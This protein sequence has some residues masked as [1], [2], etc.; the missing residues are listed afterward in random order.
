MHRSL[1]TSSAP[2]YITHEERDYPGH[3]RVDAPN[4]MLNAAGE[5]KSVQLNYGYV[6]AVGVEHLILIQDNVSITDSDPDGDRVNDLFTFQV[7]VPDGTLTQE[8]AV[9][10]TETDRNGLPRAKWEIKPLRIS[11]NTALMPAQATIIGD[12]YQ[13]VKPDL[14]LGFDIKPLVADKADTYVGTVDVYRRTTDTTQQGTLD[15]IP[16]RKTFLSGW[17]I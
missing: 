14:V 12:A 16:Q 9:Y 17:N 6:Q 4:T 8:I 10:F 11:I 15:F 3:Y 7:D 2:H 13:F 5:L 1:D